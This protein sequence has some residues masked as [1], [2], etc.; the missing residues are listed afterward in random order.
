M[1]HVEVVSTVGFGKISIGI[2]Q[3]PLAAGGTRVVARRSLRI[4]TKLGHQPRSDIVVMKVAADTQ[5][6]DLHFTG[7]E[8]LARTA[9]R[10]VLGMGKVIDVV[11]VSSDF[12]R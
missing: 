12:R 10:I 11:D 5:L 9:D 8:N 7:S 3:V 2:G 6:S 1:Q 4:Q